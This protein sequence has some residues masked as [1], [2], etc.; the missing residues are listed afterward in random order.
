VKHTDQRALDDQRDAQQRPDP[1]LAQDRIEDVGVVDV[2]DED[3]DPLGGDAS[4][5]PPPD[6]DS[7]AAL[8]LLLESPGGLRD[9]L[10]AC[11]VEQ[12]DGDGVD[13]Q[14]LLHATQQLI[15]EV[16]ELQL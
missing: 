11:L 4:R 7:H 6:R 12:Q 2:G 14:R 16:V 8:H 9:Q 3:R 10:L 5:E 15:Q 1:R 13:R